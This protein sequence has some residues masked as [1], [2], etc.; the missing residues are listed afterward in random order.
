M[1]SL[2]AQI[3]GRE[4]EDEDDDDLDAAQ[5]IIYDAWDM[6][7][8]RD[9]VALAKEALAVSP[10]CADAYVL[11]AEN[12]TTAEQ[13][14]ALYRQ[15]LAAGEQALGA[16]AF[17]D[18]VGH[19][20]GLLETRPYMR[21]RHGLALVSWRMGER[22]EAVL[23]YQDMLRLN[24]GDNQGIRYLLLDALL[25]L[26]RDGDAGKLIKRYKDDG[27]A[28]WAWSGALLSFRTDG[29]GAPSR[30]ALARAV[31]ANAHV[32]TY[33]LGKKK[34][35]RTLPAFIGLGDKN[36]AVAYVHGAAAAWARA[37]GA[38]AWARKALADRPARPG[39]SG[40]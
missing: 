4:D 27:A 8:R 33:L 31:K 25:E 23:H 21:A 15:G 12:A 9:R 39:G 29:D 40:G 34:L 28:A 7:D 22:D 11:L 2:L 26:G 1:E 20:W 18:D 36:E 3:G 24:P 10:L 35:P 19:F 14:M 30:R 17:E 16:A 38:L 6:R 13:A 37:A 32:P 5:Q